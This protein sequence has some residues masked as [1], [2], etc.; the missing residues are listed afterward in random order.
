MTRFD[1]SVSV[2]EGTGACSPTDI[3]EKGS[4][5]SKHWPLYAAHHRGGG[6]HLSGLR[7]FASLLNGRRGC[8]AG[9]DRPQHAHL[10]RLGDGA[11][12]RR[13][14]SG[15][16]S[17]GLLGDGRFL[18]DL[19]RARLGG[20]HSGCALRHRAL[21]ADRRFRD[22]G[23]RQAGR[24]L[25]RFVHGHLRGVVPVYSHPDSRRDVHVHHGLGDVGLPAGLG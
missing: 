17:A 14:L 1:G 11:S 5:S 3:A 9:A 25:C 13:R 10:R 23:V 12:G 15:E 2:D 4:N 18:Q 6:P 8:G 20:A 24:V 22:L 19:R 16:T 21:L 7:G